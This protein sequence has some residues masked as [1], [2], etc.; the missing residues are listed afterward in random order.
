MDMVPEATF[1][2]YW[3]SFARP[4]SRQQLLDMGRPP[5]RRRGEP[6]QPLLDSRLTWHVLM[7]TAAVSQFSPAVQRQAVGWL[8]NWV[9]SLSNTVGLQLMLKALSHRLPMAAVPLPARGEDWLQWFKRVSAT[10]D[11]PRGRSLLYSRLQATAGVPTGHLIV[12]SF[13]KTWQ[14]GFA[15]SF[16]P[17]QGFGVVAAHDL[18]AGAR[19][20]GCLVHGLHVAG[21]YIEAKDGFRATTLG[22]IGLINVGCVA[23]RSVKLHCRTGDV[24][25]EDRTFAIGYSTRKDLK[26]GN[27]VLTSY[28][29]VDATWKCPSCGKLVKSESST[30]KEVKQRRCSPRN[31]G[32]TRSIRLTTGETVRRAEGIRVG[33]R[34]QAKIP[35]TTSSRCAEDLERAGILLDDAKTLLEKRFVVC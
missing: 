20:S 24:P 32:T 10:S 31:A 23:C 26:Q 14:A 21:Y 19:V 9:C 18:K 8:Q 7:L 35:E 22:P 34:Y 1:V 11:N 15:V 27:S 3:S 29:F 17:D 13:V 33:T 6:G 12:R 2:R 16:R 4:I 25:E 28:S 30:K 5:K